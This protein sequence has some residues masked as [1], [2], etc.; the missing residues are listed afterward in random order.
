MTVTSGATKRPVRNATVVLIGTRYGALSDS[1]GRAVIDSVA[2][3]TYAVYTRAVGYERRV[4][5]LQINVPERWIGEVQLPEAMI[6]L[7]DE[8]G[9]FPAVRPP[10]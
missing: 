2:P 4:D 1:L 5:T 9:F 6:R 3:G 8:C 7:T 10:Q